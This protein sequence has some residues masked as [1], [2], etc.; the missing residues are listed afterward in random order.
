VVT[1]GVFNVVL[2]AVTPFP[3]T[4]IFDRPY[5]LG[6][7]VNQDAEMRP[8][9][10]L[11]AVPYANR[12]TVANA[13]NAGAT[14]GSD[15]TLPCDA[16]HAGGMRWNASA[17]AMEACSGTAWKSLAFSTFAVGGAISGLAGTL[18]LQNNLANNFSIAA[19]GSF[20][21]ATSFPAGSLYSVTVLTQPAGQTCTVTNGAGT[22]AS[23]NI[24]NVAVNCVANP[25]VTLTV[26]NY[27]SFCTVSVNGAAASTAAVQTLQVTPGI[28]VPLVAAPNSGFVFTYWLGT[29]GDSGNAAHDT[30]S[31]TSVT[32]NAAK[33]VQACCGFP[34]GGST[35]T[36]P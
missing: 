18:V 33:T 22:I 20:N 8:R 7:T 9:Q 13:L 6:V 14:I 11:N 23:A 4:V 26:A 15:N 16:A 27:L 17:L 10:L 35:C 3:A 28:L 24:T 29:F 31:S 21:F 5:S 34:G 32:V 2:G 1:N 12:A 19:N 36:A 30:Q 25:L